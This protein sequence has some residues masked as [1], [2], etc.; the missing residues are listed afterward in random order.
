MLKPYS[1]TGADNSSHALWERLCCVSGLGVF[2][3]RAT[4]VTPNPL[5]Q[6][7]IAMNC[8]TEWC[9]ECALPSS[10]FKQKNMRETAY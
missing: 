1:N 10:R 7:I 2:T 4:G 9:L 3:A 8:L 6:V 5:N